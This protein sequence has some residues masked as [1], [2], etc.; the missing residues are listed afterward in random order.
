LGGGHHAHNEHGRGV[1]HIM[2]GDAH[3]TVIQ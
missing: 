2:R 1:F 3:A